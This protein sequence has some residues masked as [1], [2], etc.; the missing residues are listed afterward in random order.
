MALSHPSAYCRKVFDNADRWAR[1][2]RRGH[3]LVK[4]VRLSD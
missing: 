3:Q 2:S 1:V 4:T